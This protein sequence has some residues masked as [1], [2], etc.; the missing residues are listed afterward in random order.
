[1]PEDAV[2]LPMSLD[3]V[4]DLAHEQSLYS[5]RS[6]N[7]YLA[8]YW[9]FRSYKADR[10][11]I[12]SLETT[13][14][15]YDRSVV[16]RFDSETRTEYFSQRSYFTSDASLSLRQNVPFTGGV[17]DVTSS[18]SRSQ[19]LDDEDDIQYASVPVSVGFSQPLNGYNR[20]R[21][22]SRIEPLKFEKAKRDYLQSLEGLAIQATDYFFGQVTAEINLKIAET[23]YSNA[24]TL[25][26][27]G[28][29]RFE[30][31]TVTQDELLDLE[32]SLLN[33]SME[34]TRA[35]VNLRQSRAALSSFLGL[36]DDVVIECE[37]PDEIPE[38]K[39][40]PEKAMTLAIE[41]NPDILDFQQRMLEAEQ[42]IARARSES[43]L[44]ANVR[45]NF[46]INKNADEVGV[47][48]GSPF[49]DQQQLRVSLSIPLLDWGLRK[50]QI[51]MARSNRDVTEATV[52]QERIDFEQDLFI[53][54]MEFN[55]QEKQVEISAKADTIAQR[56]Y[57]VTKQRFL[58]DKVD[59]IKLNSARNSLDAARRNYISSLRQY[60]RSY[61]QMR[62]YT[63]F[64]FIEDQPL[65]Q[66]L[67]YLL[68]Q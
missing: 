50:G 10:L 29:G 20:F 64:D 22:E 31:G 37:I 15:D 11:P 24:D 3:D 17:F 57:D 32:L 49:A 47:A 14:V 16:S 56:G 45:A 39:I 42:S 63:L 1:V 28:K 44:N 27:I 33:A 7:M 51:Q 19:N 38:L 60:W 54:I 65:M 55:M 12:L 36:E 62:Q 67:D 43:G 18:L 25:Y 9:E 21:W 68:Q 59:V 41:N 30:I 34:V 8:R 48:Y 2:V 53:Q 13:P 46:G 26:N 52:K 4:I 58:I 23:N 61:Y 40:D 35:Q 5:F 66:E 6:K